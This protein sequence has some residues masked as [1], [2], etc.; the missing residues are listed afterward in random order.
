MIT[1]RTTLVSG[2]VAF[3]LL[4][5]LIYKLNYVP[6]GMFISGLALGSTMIV[7]MILAALL[8]SGFIKSIF[9]KASFSRLFFMMISICFLFFHYKLYSPTLTIV[10]PSN[11]TG[12]VNL[13]LAEVD[14]NK[15]NIDTNGIGYINQWTF[16]KVYTRPIVINEKGDNLDSLLIG[17]NPS[18]FW[19]LRMACCVNEKELRIKSFKIKSN[20]K[21]DEFGIRDITDLVDAKIVITK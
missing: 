10:V 13:V 9:K 3:I 14:D 2:I 8:L 11:Y 5:S 18:A 20:K 4:I 12:E 17:Y 21:L 16:D 6:G 19:S 7:L 1:N 15:L